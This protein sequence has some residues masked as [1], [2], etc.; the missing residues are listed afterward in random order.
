M[1][2]NLPYANLDG[3]YL[4]KSGETTGDYHHLRFLKNTAFRT[5][6][7]SSPLP[8]GFCP[9]RFQS[10]VGH[11]DRRISE[12]QLLS[13]TVHK[14]SHKRGFTM[15]SLMK[16]LFLSSLFGDFFEWILN[17]I[18]EWWKNLFFV[19]KIT[20]MIHNLELVEAK[21]EWSHRILLRALC[22]MS[23][24]YWTYINGLLHPNISSRL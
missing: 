13:W 15:P 9:P 2:K 20:W 5:H 16:Y 18:F 14:S 19:R 7:F 22:G 8:T 21:D 17:N 24:W 4:Q 12:K 11:S 6:A 3:S 10:K 23:C 1:F